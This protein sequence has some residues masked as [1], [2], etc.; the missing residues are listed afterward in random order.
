M[1]LDSSQPYL[2]PLALGPQT[3]EH[4]NSRSFS[5]GFQS[6]NP[7]WRGSGKLPRG[8]RANPGQAPGGP[9]VSGCNGG[10][11]ASTCLSLSYFFHYPFTAWGTEASSFSRIAVMPGGSTVVTLESLG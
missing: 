10:D 11:A 3:R 9:G 2:C 8:N 4:G 5:W 1:G 6:T 7:P